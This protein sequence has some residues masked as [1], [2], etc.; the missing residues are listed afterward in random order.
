MKPA[1]GPGGGRWL[2][3]QV[4]A[5]TPADA[6]LAAAIARRLDVTLQTALPDPEGYTLAV[7]HGRILLRP[8]RSVA[9][10]P[11]AV[12]FSDTR[13][14]HRR[15]RGGGRRQPL[16]RAV[17]LGTA[18]ALDVVDAT[19]GLGRDAFVIASLGARIRLLERSPVLALLLEDGLARGRADPEIVS[20]VERMELIEADAVAYLG[21]LDAGQS[22]QVVYLDPMYPARTKSAKVKKE[23]IILQDLIGEAQDE[24]ALLEAA[25]NAARER[26]VVKRPGPA[27]ALAGRQSDAQTGAGN[28]R[29]DI[30]LRHGN[31]A[32]TG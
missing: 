13:L 29:F 15:L 26:V 4:T 9:R 21:G 18:R 30:Y 31:K 6:P 22:P 17:G 32:R 27:P 16:A 19:A 20:I 7:H 11:I 3:P 25:L 1:D 5:D 12:D 23:M 2:R 24:E 8:P 28:T 14:R 10:R